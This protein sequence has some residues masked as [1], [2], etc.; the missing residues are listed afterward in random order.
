MSGSEDFIAS[1]LAATKTTPLTVAVGR[2]RVTAATSTAA[3]YATVEGITDTPITVARSSWGS[4]FAASVTAGS[5]DG[6]LALVVF[7]QGQAIIVCL[8]GV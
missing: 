7:N 4:P 6:R 2:V 5:V 3:A 1:L 8:I